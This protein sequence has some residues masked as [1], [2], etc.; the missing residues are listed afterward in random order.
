MNR[1]VYGRSRQP[2]SR[3]KHRI[4]ATE[5][6]ARFA[7][8]AG[9]V[10][11][12][13]YVGLRMHGAFQKRLQQ[14]M[15]VAAATEELAAS[16]SPSKVPSKDAPIPSAI[17]PKRSPTPPSRTLS[18]AESDTTPTLR[19]NA[20]VSDR[21]QMRQGQQAP[22]PPKALVR[23]GSH[24]PVRAGLGLQASNAIDADAVR[25]EPKTP[26][27]RFTGDASNRPTDEVRSDQQGDDS[28][29]EARPEASQWRAPNI[30]LSRFDDDQT[31]RLSD[32]RGRKVVVL[33]FWAS[34]CAPCLRELPMLA[35]LVD[36]YPEDELELVAVN[37]EESSAT[38]AKMRDHLPPELKVALDPDGVAAAAFSVEALPTLVLIDRD[39]FVQRMHVGFEDDMLIRLASE[40]DTLLAGKALAPDPNVIAR[41][42][43]IAGFAEPGESLN[44]E[45][46]AHHHAATPDQPFVLS[47]GRQLPVGEIFQEA[48]ASFDKVLDQTLER[49]DERVTTI[50]YS[51]SEQASL[52]LGRRG[53]RLHGPLASFNPDGTL[54][55]CLHYRYGKRNSDVLTWDEAGRPY[56]MEHYLNGQ[57]D[58]YRILFKSCSETCDTG[59]V[60]L[61]QEWDRGDLMVTHLAM[62][63]GTSTSIGVRGEPDLGSSQR[64]EFN[65]AKAQLDAFE[66]RLDGDEEKLRTMV[67]EHYVSLRQQV[68]KQAQARLAS[69]RVGLGSAGLGSMG[70]TGP[71]RQYGQGSSFG[72][73]PSRT[74]IRNCGR[75]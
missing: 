18:N 73:T 5:L 20:N 2:T 75:S 72:F 12:L 13:A 6:L 19:F 70:M 8:A 27:L 23:D 66:S 26:R 54:L 53:S 45:S 10:A 52:I 51:G 74:T 56:V 28:L 48:K 44:H 15:L 69:G 40:L 43:D 22:R 21:S 11:C 34:W 33:D 35:K 46:A 39:G 24:V 50:R 42:H 32:F 9:C 59:H 7:L 49:Q 41:S 17:P 36:S 30:T 63:D 14:R 68:Q 31:V 57:R 55:A 25:E 58:G 64:A 47:S 29:Q 38:V 65:L 67:S 1:R 61:V 62:P 71:G 3:L 16:A 60:W 37:A 4:S